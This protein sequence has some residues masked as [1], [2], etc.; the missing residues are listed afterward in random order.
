MCLSPEQVM[1]KDYMSKLLFYLS[2][3][4]GF[5]APC[6]VNVRTELKCKCCVVHLYRW[7]DV[8]GNRKSGPTQ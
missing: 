6:H 8:L 7:T 1:S 3:T 5:G 4:I 2:W